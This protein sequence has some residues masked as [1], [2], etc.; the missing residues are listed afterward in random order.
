MLNVRGAGF[1]RRHEPAGAIWTHK[2]AGELPHAE[3]ALVL[4]LN[5]PDAYALERAP[6]AGVARQCAGAQRAMPRRRNTTR[7]C[8]PLLRE[9]RIDVVVLAGFHVHPGPKRSSRHIPTAS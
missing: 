4:A 3:I 2:A 8:W 1:R 7:R 5:S 9:H 6:E